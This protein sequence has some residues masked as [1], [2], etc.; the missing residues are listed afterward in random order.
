[1]IAEMP[2]L[3]DDWWF[4]IT[5][6]EAYFGLEEYQLA[7][8]ALKSAS[9]AATKP[10]VVPE[11]EFESAARQIASLARLQM[12]RAG[13]AD[14]MVKSEPWMVL[15]AF[16]GNRAPGVWSVFLGKVGVALSGGGFRASLFHI[17]VLAKLAELDL[18]RH[19]EVLSCVSGGSI[20]GAH[21]Y[22][23]VRRLLQSKNESDI[24][25]DDYIKLVSEL[26][27]EFLE[28]IQHD[29]RTRVLSART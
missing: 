3:K 25:R 5:V 1:L 17:G 6:A 10:G 21:Y 7:Q 24:S 16:L 18:L 22:L 14:Q 13:L 27:S 8:P 19:I 2:S 4:Q 12:E 23:K 28:G 20:I 29:I 26:A 11:W 15:E 9:D